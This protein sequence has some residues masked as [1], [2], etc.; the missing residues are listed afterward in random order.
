MLNRIVHLNQV[1]SSQIINQNKIL[2]LSNGFINI[3]IKLTNNYLY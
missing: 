2:I 3:Y 1:K